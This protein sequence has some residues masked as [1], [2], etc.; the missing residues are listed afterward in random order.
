MSKKILI[1]EDDLEYQEL[2]TAVLA[3]YALTVCGSVEEALPVVQ[4]QQFDLIIADINFFGMTGL[5][6]LNLVQTQGLNTKGPVLMCS[7]QGDCQTR[8]TVQD[9]GAVGFISKPYDPEGVQAMV[10]ALI[11]VP[12]PRGVGEE[13]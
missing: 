5:Q 8:Q 11:A 4:T 3:V 9:M 1:V 7:S 10:G 6:F 13:G 12:P 2:L